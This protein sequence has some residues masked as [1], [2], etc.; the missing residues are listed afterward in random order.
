MTTHSSILAWEIPWTEEPG[1][2]QSKRLQRSR[3]S[4]L[5]NKNSL[6]MAFYKSQINYKFIYLLFILAALVLCCSSGFSICGA[7]ALEHAKSIVVAT[8]GLSLGMWDLVP[9]PGL[10]P[11][12]PQWEHR[13][14]STGP[15]GKSLNPKYYELLHFYVETI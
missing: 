3:L 4:E 11:R 12:P 8:C 13:V 5:N 1:G 10:E 15:P 2:L 7:W 6:N 9:P 14:L